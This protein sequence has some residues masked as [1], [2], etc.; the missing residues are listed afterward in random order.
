[1]SQELKDNTVS[2]NAKVPFK[3]RLWVIIPVV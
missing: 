2:V 1:M 3:Q